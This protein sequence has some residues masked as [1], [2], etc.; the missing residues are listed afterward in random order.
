MNDEDLKYDEGEKVINYRS[1]GLC[2]TVLRR[3][4]WG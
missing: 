3:A 2:A 4:R 1:I